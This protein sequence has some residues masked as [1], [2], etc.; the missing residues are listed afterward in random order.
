MRRAPSSSRRA[1]APGSEVAEAEEE[2]AEEDSDGGRV[3]V[4]RGLEA[5]EPLH[6]LAPPAGVRAGRGGKRA[7]DHEHAFAVNIQTFHHRDPG[8]SAKSMRN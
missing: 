4:D 8:N 5:G 7:A 3:R 2:R 1:V 6:R